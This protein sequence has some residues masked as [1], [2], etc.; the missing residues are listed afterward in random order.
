[1]CVCVPFLLFHFLK[2]LL[3]WLCQRVEVRELLVVAFGIQFS[4]QGWNLGPLH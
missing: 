2:Y 1:M 4:E 3:I